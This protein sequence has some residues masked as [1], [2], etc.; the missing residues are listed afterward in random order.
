VRT[1]EPSGKVTSIVY[2]AADNITQQS[3][4]LTDKSGQSATITLTYTYDASNRQLTQ[5]LERKPYGA[6]T[7]TDS[8]E[9]VAYKRVR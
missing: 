1:T 4:L 6:T 8:M 2:D 5:K 9:A 3:Y 7:V